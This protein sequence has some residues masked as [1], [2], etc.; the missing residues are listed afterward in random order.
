MLH[1]SGSSK[2]K[3]SLSDKDRTRERL[4]V[5][6]HQLM[7]EGPFQIPLTTYPYKDIEIS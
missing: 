1:I 7:R 6:E 2:N 4:N 3:L 5:L